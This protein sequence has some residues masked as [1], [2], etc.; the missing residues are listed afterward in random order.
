MRLR[1]AEQRLSR[2]ALPHAVGRHMAGSAAGPGA[3]QKILRITCRLSFCCRL[4]MVG[5][6]KAAGQPCAGLACTASESVLGVDMPDQLSRLKGR[7]TGTVCK[8]L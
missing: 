7:L 6:Y 3:C 1:Q 4:Q 2:D 5:T 8:Q